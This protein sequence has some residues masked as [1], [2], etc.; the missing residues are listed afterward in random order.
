MSINNPR[1]FKAKDVATQ[2]AVDG[3]ISAQQNTLDQLAIL[4][5]TRGQRDVG[6]LKIPVNL[7][8]P[9][10]LTDQVQEK[11]SRAGGDE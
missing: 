1:D 8:Q 3:L 6:Q 4:R 5:Q 9:I 2:I 7:Q 10:I 11:P